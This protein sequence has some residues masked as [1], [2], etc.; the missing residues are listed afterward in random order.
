MVSSDSDRIFPGPR[1][2]IR[3]SFRELAEAAD[4]A[5]S[6]SSR[7]A[8]VRVSLALD[9]HRDPTPQELWLRFCELHRALARR[10]TGPIL[11]RARARRSRRDFAPTQDLATEPPVPLDP[12]L[13]DLE[14]IPSPAIRY[15]ATE[16]HIY[17]RTRR[18]RIGR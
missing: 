18:R 3:V 1:T 15:V 7:L 16:V 5:T 17:A 2:R 14:P 8:F 4:A 6:A 11:Q 13:D 9:L 10:I 12:R